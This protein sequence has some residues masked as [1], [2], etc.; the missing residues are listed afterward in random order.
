MPAGPLRLQGEPRARKEEHHVQ[1]REFGLPLLELQ[2]LLVRLH[3]AGDRGMQMRAG[4]RMREAL[5][6]Q[7]VR[8]LQPRTLNR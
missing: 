3:R 4:V 2:V 5:H 7:W 6:L 1:E 8:V